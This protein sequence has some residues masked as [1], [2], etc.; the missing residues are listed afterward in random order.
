MILP[1]VYGIKQLGLYSNFF[2]NLTDPL[3]L[4]QNSERSPARQN[5]LM[6]T[7]KFSLLINLCIL[8][9]IIGRVSL[10]INEWC[11]GQDTWELEEL[12]FTLLPATFPIESNLLDLR[13]QVPESKDTQWQFEGKVRCTILGKSITKQQDT[14]N[15][16]NSK[17]KHQI[18]NPNNDLFISFC[19]QILK[20]AGEFPQTFC[21]TMVS[22]HFFFVL[23]SN[24]ITGQ[25]PSDK[26]N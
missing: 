14:H 21:M 5:S 6:S 3:S 22:D 19:H 16:L 26:I 23:I 10:N 15:E 24:V 9:I 13:G 7:N 18:V 25:Q 2:M 20:Q 4:R 11:K 12:S 1:E 8:F 17:M